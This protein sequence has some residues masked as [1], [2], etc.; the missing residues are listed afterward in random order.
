VR[1]LMETLYH[2]GKILK[3]YTFDEVLAF[4]S[5]QQLAIK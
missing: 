3:E 2:N 1:D 5:Q 4:N